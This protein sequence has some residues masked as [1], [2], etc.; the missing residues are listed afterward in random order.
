MC[1]HDAS[2]QRYTES[3]GAIPGDSLEDAID[4]VLATCC[5]HYD[6]RAGWH[7]RSMWGVPEVMCSR[8]VIIGTIPRTDFQR[9]EFQ[10]NDMG[11]ALSRNSR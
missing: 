11:D 6:A 1:V 8:D 7:I 2:G 10:R 9:A 3:Y 5:S 4:H